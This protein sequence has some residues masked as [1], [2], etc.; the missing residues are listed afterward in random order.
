MASQK[1]ELWTVLRML[2]WATDYFKKKEIPDPRHS[3]EWLLAEVLECKRL[4]LYLKYDRPLS[5]QELDSIRPLVKR[6]AN[7]EPLQYIIGYTDFM[8]ARIEVNPSVL[9]PRIETEQLVELLLDKTA[10]FHANKL[11]VLDIGTGSGCIPISIKQ[12]VPNWN[13]WGMDNSE[14]ALACAKQNATLNSVDVVFFEGDLFEPENSEAE[15]L[16]LDLVVSNPPYIQPGE[17]PAIEKQVSEFEPE[18]A[19]FH[20]KPLEVY[21]S[22]TAF[23]HRKK[24]HLFLE[25]NNTLADEILGIV[26]QFYPGAKIEKD[27]DQNPRFILALIAG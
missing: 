15:N 5:Q 21:H 3:I 14:P 7:H 17:K 19:L 27:L 2:E 6:R 11:N 25:L 12:A 9:I 4:D 10:G 26:Q 22:I 20:D 16:E 1:E 24:A 8:N 18:S 23:A 13:C